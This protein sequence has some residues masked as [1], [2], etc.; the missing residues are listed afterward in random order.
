MKRYEVER[1]ACHYIIEN[2]K[3]VAEVIFQRV[4]RIGCNDKRHLYRVRS[5]ECMVTLST[6]ANYMFDEIAT[7]PFGWIG[8]VI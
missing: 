1:V 4:D 8:F 3:L 2:G 5:S 7:M 6:T